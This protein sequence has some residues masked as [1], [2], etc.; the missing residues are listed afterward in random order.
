MTAGAWT[1]APGFAVRVAGM[2][3]TALAALRFEQSFALAKELTDLGD[4]LAAEGASVS[5]TLHG[6]I[7]DATGHP[8]RVQSEQSKL[9]RILYE[10]LRDEPSAPCS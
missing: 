6:V 2:P 9:T 1:V 7:A 5:E 3:V 10:Q 8:Y 4:W